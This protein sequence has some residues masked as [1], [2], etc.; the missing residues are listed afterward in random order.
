MKKRILFFSVTAIVTY[1]L[2]ISINNTQKAES[3]LTTA[4]VIALTNTESGTVD[5]NDAYGFKLV[6]CYK[7]GTTDPVIGE[8]CERAFPEDICNYNRCW[9][10]CPD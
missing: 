6:K 8:K 2:A 7:P 5:P 9:G 3:A 1:F 10:K 4:N